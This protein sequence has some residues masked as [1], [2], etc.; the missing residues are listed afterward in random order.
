[1]ISVIILESPS[2]HSI[3][4]Q[5]FHH[6]LI[7]ASISLKRSLRPNYF[8][9][10]PANKINSIPFKILDYHFHRCSIQPIPSSRLFPISFD[11]IP[12]EKREKWKKRK[13]RENLLPASNKGY[14][15]FSLLPRFTYRIRPDA[16]AYG[17]QRRFVAQVERGFDHRHG[18]IA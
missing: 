14:T 12:L 10:L 13:L 3:Y 11:S 2:F 1:M 16:T 17:M 9:L 8:Q 18:S 6:C 4:F 15:L 7:F 5:F